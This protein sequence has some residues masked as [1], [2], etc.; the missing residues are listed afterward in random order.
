MV[1]VRVVGF[2]ETDLQHELTLALAGVDDLGNRS[3]AGRERRAKE[4]PIGAFRRA[5]KEQLK[6]VLR[7]VRVDI[8][9]DT[10]AL[11][12]CGRKAGVDVELD[13]PGVP[14][15]GGVVNM[16]GGGGRSLV[17]RDDVAVVGS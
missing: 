16:E 13:V 2:A 9:A 10:V 4:L 11:V 14:L 15:G 7:L 1:A 3:L 5:V 6:A 8:E 17:K 12:L